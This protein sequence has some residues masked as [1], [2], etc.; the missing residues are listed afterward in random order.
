MI[1]LFLANNVL[2]IITAIEEFA[3][4]RIHRFRAVTVID[5]LITDYLSFAGNTDKNTGAVFIPQSKF[6]V[7]FLYDLG[8]DFVMQEN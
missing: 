7:F 3:M 1:L 5:F 6:D 8:V 4:N 2:Y